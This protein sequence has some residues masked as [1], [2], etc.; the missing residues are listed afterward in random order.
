MDDAVLWF[1]SLPPHKKQKIRRVIKDNY[2]H[3]RGYSG[4]ALE[5]AKENCDPYRE[6]EKAGQLPLIDTEWFSFNLFQRISLP[7]KKRA[8][9]LEKTEN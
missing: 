9:T 2:Q 1:R 8:L 7:S 3:T 4:T 6:K 5:W